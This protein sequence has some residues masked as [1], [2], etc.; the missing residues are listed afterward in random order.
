[1]K[2]WRLWL[3]LGT[4]VAEH[5]DYRL[6]RL[7]QEEFRP[8]LNGDEQHLLHLIGSGAKLIAT[9][10]GME[11]ASKDSSPTEVLGSLEAGPPFLPSCDPIPPGPGIE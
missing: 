8:L 1:M 3:R 7:S 6:E 4:A 2:Y 5:D 10:A 11:A 9:L